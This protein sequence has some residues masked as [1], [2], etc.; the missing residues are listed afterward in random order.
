[1]PGSKSTS[2]L[3]A[4]LAVAAVVFFAADSFAQMADHPQSQDL[5]GAAEMGYAPFMFPQAD[6]T[7]EGFNFDLSTEIAK[8]LGRPSF[9]VVD[10]PWA[11]IFA[12]MYAKRYE[13]IAAPVTITDK[14]VKEMLFSEPYLDVRDAFVTREDSRFHTMDDLKGKKVAV[15]TG[16]VQDDWLTAN[17]DKYG[18]V[19]MRFDSTPDALQALTTGRADSHMTDALAGLWLI[20]TT[21]GLAQDVVLPPHGQLALAFRPDDTEFRNIMEHQ[22]ECMK[23]DGTLAAIYKKWF[24]ADPI[25]QSSTVV[26]YEGF[27]PQG[28]PGYDPKPHAM[29]CP[30]P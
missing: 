8:R 30:M 24:G 2:C 12:G 20:K 7:V 18:I 28:W 14:R 19:P 4:S 22:L 29:N 9:K 27:G 10:V 15:V 5:M 26:A 3:I 16:S 13:Y 6:G 17:A 11:N 23:L 25:A 1:M 21:K